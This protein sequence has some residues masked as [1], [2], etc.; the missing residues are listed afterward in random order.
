MISPHPFIGDNPMH[1]DVKLTE[2][3]ERNGWPS[4]ARP[5]LK[6]PKGWNLS[7]ITAHNRIRNHRLS[8]DGRTIAFIWDREGLS[9]VYTLPAT[10]GWPSRISTDRSLVAYWSDE[11]PQ[12]SPELQ[13]AGFHHR[14]HVHCVPPGRRRSKKKSVDLPKGHPPRFGCPTA[15]I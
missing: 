15:R 2:K 4:I 6:P 11:I 14:W 1:P 12:W 7:L 5:D 8:P 10:G 9:D 13:L 3:Y